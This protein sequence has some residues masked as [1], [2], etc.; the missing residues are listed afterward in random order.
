MVL[1]G[2]IGKVDNVAYNSTFVYL[3]YGTFDTNRPIFHFSKWRPFAILDFYA[4][5][6]KT[7]RVF[8][9]HCD[10]AKF[11]CNRCSIFDS[12]H[13]LIFCTLSLQMP[14][15]AP[16]IGRFGGFYPKNGE[17][18]E[19]H[20]KRHILG[21]KH[22]VWRMT[23][24]RRSSKS[25]HWC[26]LGASQRLKQKIK[27]LKKVYLSNHNHNMF[28]SRVRP[29]PDHPRCRSATW[30]CMCGYTR[31]VVIYSQ[32]HRNQF[33]GF[34]APGGQNLAFPI[35]L[36]IGFYNS[37]YYRTSRDILEKG[38]SESQMNS[39]SNEFKLS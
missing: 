25:V 36:A 6:D 27:K 39:N 20:P 35:T 7:R 9:G 38:R 17:Q 29:G 37:L 11:G 4:Y 1:L 5:L 30:I 24:T 32:F 22:I 18:Y 16:K 2:E 10:C 3:V 26:A 31:D 28:F 34:G 13:I 14:I 19:R 33:R 12:M 15:L 23:Y 8:G 21:R